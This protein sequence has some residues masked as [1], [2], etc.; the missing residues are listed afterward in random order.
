MS[1]LRLLLGAAFWAVFGC[2]APPAFA[3]IFE[4]QTALTTE[5]GNADR[6]REVFVSRAAGHCLLCHSVQA[7]SEPSQ[8]NVGPSLDQVGERLTAAQLRARLID[9][10]AINPDS[11]MP[12]YYRRSNLNQV[13]SRYVGKSVLEAQQIED[14]IA[15]LLTLRESAHD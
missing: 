3:E 9:S 8:G 11:A 5:P 6:G 4:Q 13:A 12:A 1:P 2:A 7:L 15:F 10:T 14:L